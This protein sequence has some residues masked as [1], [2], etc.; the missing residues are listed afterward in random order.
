MSTTAAATTSTPQ[1]QD[2]MIVYDDQLQE[3][4]Q[5]WNWASA[6]YSSTSYVHSGSY[7]V[8]VSA[9]Q[10]QALDLHHPAFINAPWSGLR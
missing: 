9:S 10:Y 3:C 1:T 6:Q 2:N 4:W 5:G 7:S 8:A